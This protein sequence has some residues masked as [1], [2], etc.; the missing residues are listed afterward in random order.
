[1]YIK[2]RISQSL[3]IKTRTDRLP[4]M[5]LHNLFLIFVLLAF[6]VT[7]IFGSRDSDIF[8]VYFGYDVIARMQLEL[9]YNTDEYRQ[10]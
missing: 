1:M 9:L 10:I 8:Q 6:N 2:T 7:N 4:A 5:C 3:L